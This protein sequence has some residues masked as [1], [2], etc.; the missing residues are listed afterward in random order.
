M[1][2]TTVKLVLTASLLFG[3]LLSAAWID[4][5]FH[6]V[7]FRANGS[8]A[9]IRMHWGNGVLVIIGLRHVTQPD[10]PGLHFWRFPHAVSFARDAAGFITDRRIADFGIIHWHEAVRNSGY[11]ITIPL[12]FLVTSF[13]AAIPAICVYRLRQRRESRSAPPSDREHLSSGHEPNF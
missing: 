13:G 6:A 12:W 1:N 10:Y 8:S 7:E 5:Q 3:G 9:G 4:G 11:G 2:N